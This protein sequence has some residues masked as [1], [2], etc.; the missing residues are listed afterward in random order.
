MLDFEN[1]FDISKDDDGYYRYNLNSTLYL[2]Y[3]YS[4]LKEYVP[5]HDLHWPIISYNIYG[6]T[7]LAWLLCKLNGV[8]DPIYPVDAGTPVMYVPKELV[9]KVIQYING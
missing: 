2:G 1:F 3:S 6:T 5:S 4:D 9:N 8:K 7:R